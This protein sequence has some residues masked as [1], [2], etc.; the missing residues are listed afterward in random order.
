MWRLCSHETT[1]R[2][3]LL[4]QPDHPLTDLTVL[5]Q[6]KAAPFVTGYPKTFRSFYA[7]VDQIKPVL[8]T[9]ISSAQHSLVVGMYGFD[10]DDLAAVIKQKLEA[11][12]IYVQLTLD[13]TQA[14]G[15]HE[16]LLL[17]EMNYPASSI[18]IGSSEHGRIIHTKLVV[19]DGLFTIGGSTNWSDA[20]ETLQDNELTVIQDPF[21]A[22]EA[23]TRLNCIH[24]NILAQ[25][26]GG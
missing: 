10:D 14:G 22:A 5:D 2:W 9:V 23:T 24:A 4:S 13:R 19:V 15:V 3:Y 26:K 11:E 25:Q 21:V 8:M 20:A 17:G 7:P 12:H 18:A 6:F 16:K 1:L